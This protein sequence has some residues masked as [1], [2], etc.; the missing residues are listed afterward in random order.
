[1]AVSPCDVIS[2]PMSCS[3][4]GI[5]IAQGRRVAYSAADADD[6]SY[7]DQK[8]QRQKEKENTRG[9]QPPE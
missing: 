3:E 4:T 1:M 2:K 5:V 8:Y 6:R 7:N 9:Q